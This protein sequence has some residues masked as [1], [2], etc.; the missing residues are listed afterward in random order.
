MKQRAPRITPGSGSRFLSDDA[1]FSSPS[2]EKVLGSHEVGRNLA[3]G[4]QRKQ[5]GMLVWAVALDQDIA[6]EQPFSMQKTAHEN[7]M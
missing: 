7:K 3:V 1:D 6:Y 4:E 5:N 2:E